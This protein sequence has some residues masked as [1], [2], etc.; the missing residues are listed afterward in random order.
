MQ[1]DFY[2]K[3]GISWHGSLVYVS[4]QALS[5]LQYNTSRDCHGYTKVYFDDVLDGDD[6]QDVKSVS[7]IFDAL[8]YRLKRLAP[9]LKTITVQSDNAS[10]YS[11]STFFSLAPVLAR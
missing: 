5:S 9:G 10:C 3:R 6:K 8:L 2:G 7:C 4:N 11:S 1:S